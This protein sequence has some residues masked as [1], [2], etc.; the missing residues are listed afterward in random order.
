MTADTPDTPESVFDAPAVP[1]SRSIGFEFRGSGSEYFRI[2]IVNLLLTIVTVGI[3]SAWAKVRRLRYFHGST[4]LDGHAFD[5]HAEP[6]AILI[7]RLITVGGYTLFVLAGKINPLLNVIVVPLLLFGLPWVIMRSRR[8]HLRMTSWRGLRFGF[9]GDYKGAFKAYI[10]WWLAAIFT[11][12]ILLPV[13]LQ[14][15]LTYLLGNSAYGSQRANYEVGVGRFYSFYGLFILKAVGALIATSLVSAIIIGLSKS[16]VGAMGSPATAV[17]TSVLFIA[18]ALL[19]AGIYQAGLLNLAFGNLRIGPHRVESTLS[20]A[21]LAGL[22]F[23]NAVLIVITLGL[24]SP[25]AKVRLI[26]YQLAHLQ[27]IATGDL[28]D[29]TASATADDS[30]ALGDE[31]SD[32][33]DVDFG[34]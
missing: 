34:I 33:F 26:R 3:Y 16:P 24:Y 30:K 31:I 12:G 19:M 8:F 22:L 4:S 17:W 18:V 9:H 29:F 7:G 28:G 1:E 27:V 25:W 5:Y 10:L 32:F 20:G 2:W 11:A 23:T 21:A 6:K 13:F 14:R 15:R